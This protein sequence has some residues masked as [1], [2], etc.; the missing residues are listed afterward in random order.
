MIIKNLISTILEKS[1]GVTNDFEKVNLFESYYKSVI[2][3]RSN[4]NIPIKM[5]NNL[6]FSLNE[7][8]YVF[9]NCPLK[10]AIGP[11]CVVFLFWIN[12][13]STID[14]KFKIYF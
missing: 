5:I 4:M 3:V 6:V 11:D 10:G 8:S 1:I 7:L 9:R 12:T 14:K 13:K 2:Q